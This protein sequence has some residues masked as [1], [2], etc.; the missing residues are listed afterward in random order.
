LDK[1]CCTC[2]A[3]EPG[4]RLCVRCANL[5][6]AQQGEGAEL[7]LTVVCLDHNARYTYGVAKLS[8]MDVIE[9][10]REPHCRSVALRNPALPRTPRLA[11]HPILLCGGRAS[12]SHSFDF[13]RLASHCG[14]IC[15]TM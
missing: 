10:S 15:I 7:S 4:M 5:A 1:S 9:A 8:M 2:L 6:V 14:G 3:Q 13:T 11:G 12:V